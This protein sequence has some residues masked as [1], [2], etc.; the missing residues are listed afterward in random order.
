MTIMSNF[1]YQVL[2]DIKLNMVPPMMAEKSLLE[3]RIKDYFSINIM[4]VSRN[5]N[6]L[7]LTKDTVLEKGDRV[8]AFGPYENMKALFG[9]VPD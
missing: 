4:M 9:D 7:T 1:G 2:V 6:P 5:D 8:I 3:S